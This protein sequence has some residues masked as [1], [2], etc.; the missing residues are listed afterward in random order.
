MTEASQPPVQLPEWVQGTSTAPL[1]D[2]DK[3][4]L[5]KARAYA[6]DLHSLLVYCQAKDEPVPEIPPV[7]LSNNPFLDSSID[8][9]TLH[10]LS[11]VYVGSI[12]PELNED[13]IR[14]I[15]AQY[16][17]VRELSM[18]LDPLT[19]NHRGFCFMEYEVPD[20]GDMAVELLD[21]AR[22]G[23][24][25]LRVG[26]PNQYNTS[27]LGTL[28]PTVPG[29]LYIASVNE[30]IDESSLRAVFE[31]FGTLDGL[32]LIPDVLRRRH[33]GY[34]YLQYADSASADMALA[35]MNGFDLAGLP[36]RLRKSAIGAA[37]PEGM[38]LIER[39]GDLKV[40]SEV[41]ANHQPTVALPHI[42][43]AGPGG[44]G[45]G[46]G[47]APPPS[48]LG[49]V[50]PYNAPGS[51]ANATAVATT[52]PAD[53]SSDTTW[54]TADSVAHEEGNGNLTNAQQRYSLMQKLAQRGVSTV[55]QVT[56]VVA[57]E[58]VDDELREEFGEECAK[59]GQVVKV[60]VHT[61]PA[62]PPDQQVKVFVQ[63]LDASGS[64][65][66]LA[67]LNGRWFGGRQLAARLYDQNKF[68][69]D[70]YTG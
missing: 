70:D 23:N 34:G 4:N 39:L 10:N 5:E 38:A 36:L 63:F 17:A 46:A 15:M 11:K 3:V 27:L 48:G 47:V 18:A 31:P 32:V 19:G 49:N 69:A 21:G 20:A 66:A 37:L 14:A 1:S 44:A 51:G 35:A 29:R 8:P 53:P 68:Y 62:N 28:P 64:Q 56:N 54:L 33:K 59:F 50:A 43:P 61:E 24:K 45:M 26:R 22:V 58:E 2:Q 30:H 12:S 55:L 25:A 40:P 65:A 57:L 41:F 9:T 60:A 16:G 6:K 52:T 13:H 42:Q 7:A 67:A